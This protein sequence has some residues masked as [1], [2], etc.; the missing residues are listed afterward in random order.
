[1]NKVAKQCNDSFF[2]KTSCDIFCNDCQLGKNRRIFASP[3]QSK[4]LEPLELV[5]S[6]VWGPAPVDSPEGY[7]YYLLFQDNFSRFTWI[8]PMK[9]KSEVSKIFLQFK[10]MAENLTNKKIK[11]FQVDWGGEF[12]P[13]K[14]LLANFGI[15]FQ[16]PCPHTQ[17]NRKIERKHRHITEIA[18]TLLAQ[19]SMP[20]KYW[21][22]ACLTSTFLINHLKYWRDACSKF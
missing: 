9:L 4:C 8:Y 11:V 10:S 13:L 1:M 6:D 2:V 14:P 12:R 20:L 22:D 7:K 5:F 18:L 16:H 17:S 3:S 15:I 19:S 21:R